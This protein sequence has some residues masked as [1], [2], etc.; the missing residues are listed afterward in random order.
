VVAY[1]DPDMEH[2]HEQ[3]QSIIRGHV[4]SQRASDRRMLSMIAWIEQQAGAGLDYEQGAL[5]DD[6]DAFTTGSGKPR[7]FTKGSLENNR[8]RDRVV[9]D[10][11]LGMFKLFE[12]QGDGLLKRMGISPDMVGFPSGSK[13]NVRVS[14]GLAKLRMNAGLITFRD[15]FDNREISMKMLGKKLA[16]LIQQYP[17]YKIQRISNRPEM[18]HAMG[19][20]VPISWKRLVEVSP[21]QQPLELIKEIEETEKAQ[22]AQQQRMQKLNEA[23]QQLA[24]AQAESEILQNRQ[25]AEQQRTAALENQSE[26]AYDRVKT[27][28]EIQELQSKGSLE[29]LKMAVDLEKAR[30]GA[31]KSAS[32]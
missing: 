15:L 11:P 13:G 3:I 30:L 2:S 27:A 18:G 29:V 24:I 4:D 14:G 9:P 22:Q 28:A 5:M 23:L 10:I 26:A 12:E 21:I 6:E 1:F 32:D 7:V 16:R 25:L 19:D 20:P 31:Q 17:G 8:A